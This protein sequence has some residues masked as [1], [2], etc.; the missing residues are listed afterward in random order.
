[1]IICFT[2]TLIEILIQ[3]VVCISD[4]LLTVIHKA[5]RALVDHQVSDYELKIDCQLELDR[6][7]QVANFMI[8]DDATIPKELM[9]LLEH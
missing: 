7:V 4:P 5:E 1:M 2:N 8:K 6:L 9:K 3:Y